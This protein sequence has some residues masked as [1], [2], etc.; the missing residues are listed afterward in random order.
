MLS[1]LHTWET[2]S[3][4]LGGNTIYETWIE[5][6]GVCS[7]DYTLFAL[8]ARVR[9]MLRNSLEPRGLPSDVCSQLQTEFM[10]CGGHTPSYVTVN[11]FALICRRAAREDRQYAVDDKVWPRKSKPIRVTDIFQTFGERLAKANAAKSQVWDMFDGPYYSDVAPYL[12]KLRKKMSY[13]D[14][15]GLLTIRPEFRLVFWFDS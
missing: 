2:S 5:Q 13:V 12:R 3:Y 6:L 9:G 8:L 15:N 14:P 11:E 10:N 4:E 7:R 1:P